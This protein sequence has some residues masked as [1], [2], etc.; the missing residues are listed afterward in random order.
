MLSQSV[1]LPRH[2]GKKRVTRKQMLTNVHP[3]HSA[4]F[5]KPLIL[6]ALSKLARL[7]LYLR[8]NKNKNMQ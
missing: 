4:S 5:P 3:S 1:T 7:L 2:A 8:Y 6:W